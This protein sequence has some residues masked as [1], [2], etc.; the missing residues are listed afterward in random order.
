M[1]EPLRAAVLY[2]PSSISFP[3]LEERKADSISTVMSQDSFP[4]YKTSKGTR[5][6]L[7]GIEED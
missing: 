5:H 1:I 2:H 3:A 7:G 4:H 6:D